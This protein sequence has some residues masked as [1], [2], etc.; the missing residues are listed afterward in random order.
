MSG[1]WEN[2]KKYWH[3]IVSRRWDYKWSAFSARLI[4]PIMGLNWLISHQ[5]RCLE[6]QSQNLWSNVSH[7][8]EQLNTEIFLL[9]NHDRC[10]LLV[11]SAN[12]FGTFLFHAVESK[13]LYLSSR[14]APQTSWGF[15]HLSPSLL[16]LFTVMLPF[17]GVVWLQ[18][19]DNWREL[20]WMF[21]IYAGQ[22]KFAFY[23]S[24]I[25][26]AN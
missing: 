15:Q 17:L 24:E 4:V 16:T 26:T 21:P 9:W 3:N 8:T 14:G 20:S 10:Q 5:K 1:S 12:K 2:K 25:I 7:F 6:E 23:R 18:N 11:Y 22:G 19:V 13:R